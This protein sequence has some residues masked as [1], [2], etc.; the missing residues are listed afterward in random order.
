MLSVP[1]AFRVFRLLIIEYT[2]LK[3]GSGISVPADYPDVLAVFSDCWIGPT[4]QWSKGYKN[5]LS[6]C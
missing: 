4:F 3:D 2:S 6:T 5:I 1:P